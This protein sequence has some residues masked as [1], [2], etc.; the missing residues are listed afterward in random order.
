MN[1][2]GLDKERFLVA[3]NESSEERLGFGQVKIWNGTEPPLREIRSLVVET[4]HR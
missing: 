1:P 4:E 3:V 2:I